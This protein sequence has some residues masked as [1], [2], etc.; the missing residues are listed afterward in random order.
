MDQEKKW[1]DKYSLRFERPHLNS[2]R[3]IEKNEN[4][5][6][7]FQYIFIEEKILI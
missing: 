7:I 2:I 5:N 6:R 1:L 3:L 4:N